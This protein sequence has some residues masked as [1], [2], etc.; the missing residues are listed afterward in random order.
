M[1]D[2]AGD[3]EGD[4]AGVGEGDGEGDAAGVGEGD[5]SWARVA[6]ESHRAPVNKKALANT[7]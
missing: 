4:A 7:R 6:R 2:V 1:D 5:G 3:G